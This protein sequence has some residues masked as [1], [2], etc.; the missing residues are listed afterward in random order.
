MRSLY[1]LFINVHFIWGITE[2]ININYSN[3]FFNSKRLP[4]Y[5]GISD[6]GLNQEK[7]LRAFCLGSDLAKSMSEKG[8]LGIIEEAKA[9]IAATI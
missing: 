1:Y 2:W 9:S 5:C 3:F 8:A 6:C 4:L 7:V